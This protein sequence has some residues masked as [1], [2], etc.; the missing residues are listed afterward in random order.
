[1]WIYIIWLIITQLFTLILNN[2]SNKS[3]KKAKTCGAISHNIQK[4]LIVGLIIFSS[5]SLYIFYFLSLK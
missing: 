2:K 5:S 4:W 1:M 3:K